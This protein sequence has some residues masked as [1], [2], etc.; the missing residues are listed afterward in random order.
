M[1][2]CPS[3][4]GDQKRSRLA[5]V[6]RI[7]KLSAVSGTVGQG[8]K[9]DNTRSKRQPTTAVLIIRSVSEIAVRATLLPYSV[10]PVRK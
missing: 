4:P 5:L 3:V 10:T 8:R 9:A 7:F 6:Y 1:S 2:A